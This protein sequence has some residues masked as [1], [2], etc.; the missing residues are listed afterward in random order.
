MQ[1]YSSL[2]EAWGELKP[3]KSRPKREPSTN[4][5][6]SNPPTPPIVEEP[7]AHLVSAEPTLPSEQKEVIAIPNN[8]SKPHSDQVELL[9]LLLHISS[10]VF[11]IVLIDVILSSKR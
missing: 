11:L 10:G 6:H 8:E 4:M 3:K 2:D 5:V 1:M 7:S 9:N